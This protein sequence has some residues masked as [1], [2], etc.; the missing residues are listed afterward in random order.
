MAKTM[1]KDKIKSRKDK[2]SKKIQN[3]LKKN[4]F[5]KIKTMKQ[6]K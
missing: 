1:Q 2:K 3:T 6:M 5:V 4:D